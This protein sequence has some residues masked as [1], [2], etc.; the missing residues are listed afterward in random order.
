MSVSIVL[1]GEAELS[2]EERQMVTGCGDETGTHLIIMGCGGVP[3]VRYHWETPFTCNAD[4]ECP[5]GG[6]ISWNFY[7]AT[8]IDGGYIKHKP[9]G[10]DGTAHQ[11]EKR[12]IKEAAVEYVEA[13]KRFRREHGEEPEAEEPE[14]EAPNVEEPI[15]PKEPNVEEPNEEVPKA[16]EPNVEEPGASSLWVAPDV[17]ASEAAQLL[18]AFEAYHGSNDHGSKDHGSGSKGSTS[19]SSSSGH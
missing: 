3:V 9:Q 4:A 13:M 19:A 18:A 11:K 17:S 14:A 7:G 16:K 2:H 8:G 15:E 12:R 10:F 5:C 6:T 1:K